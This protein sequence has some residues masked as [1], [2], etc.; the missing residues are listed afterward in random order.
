M[1]RERY[2]TVARSRQQSGRAL[3]EEGRGF[4]RALRPLLKALQHFSSEPNQNDQ[5]QIIR[6]SLSGREPEPV[7][8]THRRRESEREGGR[9]RSSERAADLLEDQTARDGFLQIKVCNN[10]NPSS[11]ALESARRGENSQLPPRIDLC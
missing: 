6:R 4:Q 2:W 7:R 11:E 5:R 8:Q 3:A 10:L 1:G 9:Q